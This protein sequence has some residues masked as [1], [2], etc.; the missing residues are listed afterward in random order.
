MYVA[1]HVAPPWAGDVGWSPKVSR[2]ECIVVGRRHL[3]TSPS[4]VLYLD[5]VHEFCHLV[6]RRSGRDLWDMSKGYVR[7]PTELEAYRMAVR[8]ARSLGAPEK[9]LREYLR[10]EW[11]EEKD[12]QRLLRSLGVRASARP[13]ARSG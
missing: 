9:F 5:L 8:E 7:S 13:P 4:L 6:Q 10:V 11:V 3:R 12:H 1:P 2:S